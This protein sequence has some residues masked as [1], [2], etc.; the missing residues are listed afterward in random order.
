MGGAR[1]RG[2]NWAPGGRASPAGEEGFGSEGPRLPS[3]RG[4]SA[5]I[6]ALE[7]SGGGTHEGE[8]RTRDL[9]RLP[10]RRDLGQSKLSPDPS[11]GG[12]GQPRHHTR[13]TPGSEQK[14]LFAAARSPRDLDKIIALRA[15]RGTVGRTE[16]TRTLRGGQL[17]RPLRLPN[18]LNARPLAHQRPQQP[19]VVGAGSAQEGHRLRDAL[20]DALRAHSTVLFLASN[21]VEGVVRSDAAGVGQMR[22]ILVL[23]VVSGILAGLRVPRGLGS[24][25]NWALSLGRGIRWAHGARRTSES[26]KGGVHQRGLGHRGCAGD[27]AL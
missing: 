25:A 22:E 24:G 18:L 8:P 10:R 7:D 20:R 15:A 17:T 21:R 26:V 3:R 9:L 14:A 2:G 23:L 19:H 16:G 4:P 13:R 12:A 11:P 1:G 27:R 6:Q 5:A